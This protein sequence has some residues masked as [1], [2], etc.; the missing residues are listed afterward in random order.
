MDFEPLE[1]FVSIC[2]FV[3]VII[4]FGAGMICGAYLF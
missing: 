3:A 1:K 2:I 4:I